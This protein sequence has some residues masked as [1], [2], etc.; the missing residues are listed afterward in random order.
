[1]IDTQ[2]NVVYSA[3]KGVDLGTNLLDG[4][5]RLSNLSE[6]YRESM[7]RNI[8]G[9]VVLAD[10]AAY[11]P[12]LGNPAGWAVTP[13]A[14]DGTVVGALAIELPIDRI[15]EVMTADG[16]WQINGLGQTGETYLVGRDGYMRSISRQLVDDPD[17]IRGCRRLGRPVAERRRAQ[18]AERQHAAAADRERCGGDL[19][20]RRRQRHDARA[21]L[22]RPR[23]PHRV[24]AAE[25]RRPQLGHR[26]A[27]GLR[28]GARAG[29]GLHPQPDPVHRRHDHLRLP[30]LA[31]AR[32]GVR[33]AAAPPQDRGPAH[34]R[35]R[36]GRAGRRRLVRRAGR[37]RDRVQRHEP[38]PAGQIE[39]DRR[40]GEDERAADPLVHARGH[41]R[42]AT[43][44]AT[45]RSRRRTRTSRSSSPT[46]SGSKSS[47]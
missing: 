26:R 6:A 35:G 4:P 8:V 28:R 21:L 47:P 46:S 16:E 43:S 20:A 27:G 32:A 23:Q 29:R 40:A 9:E 18:R 44:T 1:M 3:F 10:F 36:G 19:G 41:G 7:S 13:I 33:P 2:G 15:N 24:R 25:R 45:R 37:R 39:P 12:S 42:A 30:A 17:R 34:R 22:P 31:R 14:V 5:Y 38:Q 11:S